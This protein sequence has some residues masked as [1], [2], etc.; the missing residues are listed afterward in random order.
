MDDAHENTA[1][2]NRMIRE[3]KAPFRNKKFTKEYDD[4]EELTEE[5]P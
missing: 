4:Y 3:T 1:A 2:E 5:V